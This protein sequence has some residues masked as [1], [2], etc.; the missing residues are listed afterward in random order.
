[1]AT[2]ISVSISYRGNR[3]DSIEPLCSSGK[4]IGVS[5]PHSGPT[6]PP[7]AALL[8]KPNKLPMTIFDVTA[9]Y[10][11]GLTTLM[12]EEYSRAHPQAQPA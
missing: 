6:C 2:W 11:R 12:L 4:F 5:F 3:R 8:Q 7:F 1:V 9:R 10:A